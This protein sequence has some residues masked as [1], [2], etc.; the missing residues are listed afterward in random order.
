MLS[1]GELSRL[2]GVKIPTIRYYEQMKLID[3]PERLEGNQRRF[4]P[5]GSNRPSSLNVLAI[6]DFDCWDQGTDRV[7]AAP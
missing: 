7:E 5:D 3:A 6:L 1:I 2:A 4:T